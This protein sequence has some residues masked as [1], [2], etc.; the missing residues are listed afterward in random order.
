MPSKIDF[1][2]FYDDYLRGT[3]YTTAYEEQEKRFDGTKFLF[4]AQKTKILS[5]FATPACFIS[6]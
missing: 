3:F 5:I 1:S 4:F 6:A 2:E